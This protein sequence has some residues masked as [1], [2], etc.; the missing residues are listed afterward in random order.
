MLQGTQKIVALRHLHAA[1]SDAPRSSPRPRGTQGGWGPS[2]QPSLRIFVMPVPIIPVL[3]II[4]SK[5]FGMR[6]GPKGGGG[7]GG[8]RQHLKN[9]GQLLGGGGQEVGVGVGH[10]GPHDTCLAGVPPSHSLA[11]HKSFYQPQI[12]SS[13]KGLLLAFTYSLFLP[14]FPSIHLTSG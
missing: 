8:Q 12:H 10:H 1:F 11:V 4:L 7:G 14:A 3:I 5:S 6:S 13:D 2:L 9:Y